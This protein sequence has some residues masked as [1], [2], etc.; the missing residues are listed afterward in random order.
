MQDV[1]TTNEAS[2][3]ESAMVSPEEF[4]LFKQLQ[5]KIKKQKEM[6]GQLKGKLFEELTNDFGSAFFNLVK[7]QVTIS[8]KEAY[9]DGNIYA[10]T[11]GVDKEE[12]E[13]VDTKELT[14]RV[15]DEYLSKLEP[16]MGT[17]KSIKLTGTYEGKELFWQIRK[18]DA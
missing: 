13:E 18:R 5:A 1:A 12:G 8:T 11:F 14:T 7:E 4:E 2:F 17:A 3:D 6:A 9:S 10:I 15:I 16:M